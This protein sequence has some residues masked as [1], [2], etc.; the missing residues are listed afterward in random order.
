MGKVWCLTLFPFK[1][2]CVEYT[3]FDHAVDEFEYG[4]DSIITDSTKTPEMDVSFDPEAIVL[5]VFL[6]CLCLISTLYDTIKP[7]LTPS[8]KP[9]KL[10]CQAIVF[11]LT[12]LLVG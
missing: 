4:L 7:K 10:W 11:L 1:V 9:C 2:G 3:F 12:I 6:G 5:S 8:I